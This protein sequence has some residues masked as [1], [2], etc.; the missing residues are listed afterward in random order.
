MGHAAAATGAGDVASEGSALRRA[1]NARAERPNSDR[2]KEPNGFASME[3]VRSGRPPASTVEQAVARDKRAGRARERQRVAPEDYECGKARPP[4]ASRIGSS[5]RGSYRSRVQTSRRSSWLKRAGV[6]LL[7]VAPLVV[8][9]EEMVSIDRDSSVVGATGSAAPRPSLISWSF[10]CQRP[11]WR[12]S[13]GRALWV[14]A[15]SWRS[16]GLSRDSPYGG[17]SLHGERSTM[18]PDRRSRFSS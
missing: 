12:S 1:A 3:V 14:A 9:V 5:G 13:N 7:L 17:C 4:S 2:I 18:R 10:W 11:R 6:L 16:L 15:R 8:A